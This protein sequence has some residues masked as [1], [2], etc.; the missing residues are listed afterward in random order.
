[1]RFLLITLI[2]SIGGCVDMETGVDSSSNEKTSLQKT[3]PQQL[4]FNQNQIID[5]SGIVA[6][7]PDL[8]NIIVES[9]GITGVMLDAEEAKST[10]KVML[11]S[12]GLKGG[13]TYTVILNNGSLVQGRL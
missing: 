2:I 6:Q 1:M 9:E 12:P 11:G 4:N 5:I 8:K 13:Y 7:Y 3:E 10:P